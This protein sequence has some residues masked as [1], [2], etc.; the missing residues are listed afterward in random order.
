MVRTRECG[1]FIDLT[2]DDF[3]ANYNLI[4][5]FEPVFLPG[6]CGQYFT[7]YSHKKSSPGPL[8]RLMA[9]QY[10]LQKICCRSC[11]RQYKSFPLTAGLPGC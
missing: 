1:G 10:L 4:A 9:G 7:I 11:L 2:A 3:Y 6:R 8:Q 5:G